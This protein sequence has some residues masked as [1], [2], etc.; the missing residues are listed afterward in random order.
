MI[1][2][3]YK[4][5]KDVSELAAVTSGVSLKDILSNSRN[6]E[7]VIPRMVIGNIL[8]LELNYKKQDIANYLNRDRTSIYHYMNGHK[9]NYRYWAEYR[10]LY[11]EI[12]SGY[13]GINNASMT[14]DEMDSIISK[15]EIVSNPK[16]SRFMISFKIGK[17]ETYIYTN[18]LERDITTL[19][20]LFKKYNYIFKIEHR[21]TWS[22]AG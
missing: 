8:N 12:K 10:E 21:N 1:K 20:N 2:N 9:S 14:R 22:Y 6:R 11:D 5:F 15:S 17:A 7:L 18:S 4:V 13:V 16:D 19:K 3:D